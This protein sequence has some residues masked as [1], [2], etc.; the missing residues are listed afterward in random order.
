MTQRLHGGNVSEAAQRYGLAEDDILD[1]SANVNPLGPSPASLKAARTS[2]AAVDRYPDSDTPELKAA[3]ARYFG[4]RPDQV[5][6]GNGSTGLIHLIPRVFRPKRVLITAPTFTEYAAA[7]ADAGG[8]VVSFPLREQDGFR[9]DPLELA[10]QL[11]GV[12]MAILC[13][14]N[15]PTG[16]LVKKVE[17]DRIVQYTL[18]A[19]V[20]LV[21]DEAFMDFAES[22]SIA[23]TATEF[24]HVVCIRAFTKFFAL[25]GLRIGYLLSH[26]ANIQALRA[27]QEPWTVSV[28]AE[29]AA[30]AAL[31]D[32]RY[33]SKTHRL[34]TRERAWLQSMLRQLSGIEPVDGSANFLFAKL[35]S[36]DAGELAHALG[37][38]GILVRDCSSFPGLGNQYVRI[39]VRTRR[40]NE[41]LA[42]AL[43]V[44][45]AG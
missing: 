43:A 31:R 27:G 42:H 25:A 44:V 38:R 14:P 16:R 13:N 1:F 4:V 37:R 21:V 30:V 9:V 24:P 26:E 8:T 3:C 20:K 10:P 19:G 6:C 45:L 23:R 34:V 33:I 12:D 22:E 29:R 5:L 36:I 40:E 17:M 2:L 32:E 39:A 35:S 41:R 11:K 28:P 7:V 15:N 18:D